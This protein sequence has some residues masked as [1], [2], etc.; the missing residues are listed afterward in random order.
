MEEGILT[1][2]EFETPGRVYYL[3]VLI[4]PFSKDM[5]GSMLLVSIFAPFIPLIKVANHN[6]TSAMTEEDTNRE[7]CN[8]CLA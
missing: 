8:K 1:D 6:A 4:D 7:G 2:I 5:N 3:Q